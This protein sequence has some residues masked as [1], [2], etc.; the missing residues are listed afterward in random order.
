MLKHRLVFGLLLG[1][2]SL[3]L[4]QAE[5][6]GRQE[7]KGPSFHFDAVNVATPGH[8]E[9]S[10]MNLFIEVVYDE[11]Q[12][13]KMADSYEA[14]YEVSIMIEDK[15]GDQVDGK[16]Y[17]ETVTVSKFDM[18]NKRVMYSQTNQHFDLEPGAYK[19]SVEV[20]DKETDSNSKLTRNVKL[21]D[22]NKQQLATSDIMFLSQIQL[23]ST[24]TLQGIRPQVTDPLKGLSN[25]AYAYLEIYN[26]KHSETVNVHYELFNESDK[27]TLRKELQIAS[28]QEKTMAFF[29][30]KVD[31][32][33][34]GIYHLNVYAVADKEKVKTSKAFYVRWRSLPVNARDLNDAIDQLRYIANKEEWKKLKKAKGDQRL[35]EYKKFWL[36]R[37]PSPGTEINEA[38]DAHYNRIEYA[39]QN[40]SAM[41]REGWRT[42]M[43]M[44]FIILGAPDDVERNAYPRYSK[45]YEIWYYYR[46]NREFLFL[47]ITGFG[48][49]HLDNPYS[50]Y[51]FQRLIDTH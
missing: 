31:S 8:Y 11:L 19:V 48:D 25:P 7:S 44:L 13:V 39:N 20:S 29:P 15:D 37:D 43:G 35:Q 34:H 12:F 10:R 9:Q 3:I 26:P 41:Q 17:H 23:D 38:M 22:F 40:F 28:A 24:G 51:E 1:F 5:M 33:G 47:D 46:Y 18:T 4:A 30:I 49:Y 42:D 36:A 16:T 2:S 6:S 32:L 50:I 45:P 14:N 27:K 21:A